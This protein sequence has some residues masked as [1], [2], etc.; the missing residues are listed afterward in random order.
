MS[1]TARQ[2]RQLF[3]TSLLVL[4]ALGLLTRPVVSATSE[5]HPVAHPELAAYGA[6]E[7]SHGESAEDADAGRTSEDGQPEHTDGLHGLMHQASGGAFDRGIAALEVPIVS[8]RHLLVPAVSDTARI[9]E[10]LSSPFR[11]PIA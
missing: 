3:C 5:M 2:L 8:G 4:M 11:P 10:R 1:K 7:H 9:P 6:D